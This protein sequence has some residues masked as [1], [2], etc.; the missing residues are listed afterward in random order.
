MENTLLPFL[1]YSKVSA[2]L[3]LTNNQNSLGW[4]YYLLH[5]M[6]EYYET[7]FFLF[8]L[9]LSFKVL[10]SFCL[11]SPFSYH[12]TDHISA[13]FTPGTVFKTSLLYFLFNLPC[14]THWQPTPV[15]LPGK[16]HGLRSLVGY[17][18]WGCKESD[19]TERLL[20]T[21]YNSQASL[22]AQWVKNM[23]VKQETWHVWVQPLGWLD[24]PE[25]EMATHS[26]TLVWEI[27]WTEEPG[28]LQSKGSKS[29]GHD[30]ATKYIDIQLTVFSP[31]S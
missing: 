21:L 8:S 6:E 12:F 15:L 29:I 20:F 24:P 26:S 23:P 17:S 31:I 16:S 7:L 13:Y 27:P 19:T 30:R 18:P 4:W 28:G 9:S 10:W 25:K 5:N 3:V 14:T 11:V 22:M 2:P 1:P